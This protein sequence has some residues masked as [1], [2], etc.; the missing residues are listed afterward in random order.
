MRGVGFKLGL[1][2][3]RGGDWKLRGYYRSRMLR[4]GGREVDGDAT[5]ER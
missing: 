2:R 5:G 1:W 4:L 3:K